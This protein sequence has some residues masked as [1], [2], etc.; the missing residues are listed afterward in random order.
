M[1]C[2][3]QPAPR[4]ARPISAGAQIGSKALQQA[5]DPLSRENASDGHPIDA[6]G[7][8][9][10]VRSHPPACPTQVADIGH[11]IP[12]V[13]PGLV[14]VGL[15]LLIELALNA[16]Y[17]GGVRLK[18][19]AHRSLLR[20][21]KLIVFLLPFATCAGG[22]CWRPIVEALGRTDGAVLN[23]QVEPAAWL[24]SDAASLTTGHILPVTGAYL[25]RHRR[26]LSAPA[27]P[28]R[29]RRSYS[30]AGPAIHGSIMTLQ[31][32]PGLRRLSKRSGRASNPTT[33]VIMARGSSPPELSASSVVR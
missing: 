21:T 30:W 9:A 18:I 19:C 27:A 8:F 14:R 11:P 24:C 26:W 4:R 1:R 12:Q 23:E 25:A 31:S 15:T 3:D 7:V 10:S 33:S 5:V 17:P 6:G 22:R 29:W 2:S 32:R 16:E 28:L 20:H 13:S